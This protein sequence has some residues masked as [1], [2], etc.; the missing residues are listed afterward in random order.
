MTTPPASRLPLWKRLVFTAVPVILLGAT[1]EVGAVLVLRHTQGYDGRHL[2]H[3]V[4]DPYKNVL[5][6]PNLVDLRG[7]RHESHGFRRDTD[8]SH[9]KPPGTYRIFLMGASTAY[10][11]GGLWPHIQRD[12]PVLQS[13]QTIDH[14]LEEMLQDSLGVP[15]EVINAAIASVW[16]HHH[17]IYLNQT[18]LGFDPDMILF[19]DG[20]NDWYMVDPSHDQFASYAYQ[21]TSAVI[22]GDPTL[23]SLAYMN[24]WWIFRTSAFAHLAIR[25][26]RSAKALLISP[27][28]NRT[29]VNVEE[30]LAIHREVFGRTALKMIDRIAVLL[31]HEGIR[32]VFMQQPQLILERERSQMPEVER[33]LFEFNVASWLPGWEEFIHRAVP[34]VSRRVA[35]TVAKDGQTYLDLT[36]ILRQMDGQVFTDYAHLTPEANHVLAQ[37]VFRHIMPMI[38]SD[39]GRVNRQ[40]F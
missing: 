35:E 6:T 32:A 15:V 7:V 4:F 34:E 19:L 20:F 2:L 36:G 17:L 38:R 37:R 33:R 8:V 29:P 21:E 27:P 1:L 14:Y 24:S 5:P 10:G 16:M 40:P 23:Y 31:H 18:I 13:D 30:A 11:L 28:K 12:W 39:I 25:S 22:M 3:Y 26:L 9:A